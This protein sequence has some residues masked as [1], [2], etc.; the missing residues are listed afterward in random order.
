MSI[1]V[2]VDAPAGYADGA[3]KILP[4]GTAKGF[5]ISGIA[6]SGNGLVLAIG[7]RDAATPK[8]TSAGKV[9]IYD[10]ADENFGTNWVKRGEVYP[11]GPFAEDNGGDYANLDFGFGIALSYDGARMIVGAPKYPP[12]TG[13][14]NDKGMVVTFNWN[15][16]SWSEDDY[17]YHPGSPLTY[18]NWGKV[19]AI[20]GD[21]TV[22]VVGDP[23]F[24][25]SGDG[26]MFTYDWGGSSWTKRTNDWDWDPN[27]FNSVAR[28]GIALNHAG[29]RVAIAADEDATGDWV[30]LIMDW[31]TTQWGTP[32]IISTDVYNPP[33]IPFG[34]DRVTAISFMNQAGT[35]FF[36]AGYRWDQYIFEFTTQW[37]VSGPWYSYFNNGSDWDTERDWA[38]IVAVSHAADPYVM[39]LAD[40][41]D[42]DS[43]SGSDLAV[44][45]IQWKSETE[46]TCLKL[47]PDYGVVGTVC[48]EPDP[49]NPVS[50][51]PGLPVPPTPLDETNIVFSIEYT[52]CEDKL[53]AILAAMQAT[54]NSEYQRYLEVDY[55]DVYYNI[56]G[57]CP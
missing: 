6:L 36:A 28:D 50:T 18:Q 5:G 9:H 3:D 24:G 14:T 48:R 49:P 43:P 21:G 19:L 44:R 46:G 30:V 11:V 37:D 25:P 1:L 2:T 55:W 45:T 13:A 47:V 39:V 34:G 4:P 38:E 40:Y 32:T 31:G 27:A 56:D 22:M 7:E 16:S 12:G 8:S 41:N 53:A 42:V 15:G 10:R 51:S 23:N 54:N 33:D 20:S 57:S 52:S 26:E 17:T 29:D 35:K